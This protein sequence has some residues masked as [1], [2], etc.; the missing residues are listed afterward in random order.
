MDEL[1]FGKVSDEFIP[2]VEEFRAMNSTDSPQPESAPK[3]SQ[4][5]KIMKMLLLV[6][7]AAEVG[8]LMTSTPKVAAL[9]E[10]VVPNPEEVAAYCEDIY[11]LLEEG[12]KQDE[13]IRYIHENTGEVLKDWPKMSFWCSYSYD[14]NMVSV[15]NNYTK[16]KGY[17]PFDE[18][19][20][21]FQIQ[22]N[23][24][25][26]ETRCC[27]TW[28]H[29]L[30][31]VPVQKEVT[32]R[33]WW[34]LGQETND[35]VS[36]SFF[37]SGGVDECLNSD[38]FY[39]YHTYSEFG[40]DDYEF[41]ST[42]CY[43]GEVRDGHFSGDIVFY[44]SNGYNRSLEDVDC[45]SVIDLTK[46][47]RLDLEN[48]EIY[49]IPFPCDSKCENEKYNA[50]LEKMPETV[51]YYSQH[52]NGGYRI[53]LKTKHLDGGS[54]LHRAIYSRDLN[55][56]ATVQEDWSWDLDEICDVFNA[57]GIHCSE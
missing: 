52:I 4:T 28:S 15:L 44:H 5:R 6:V 24:S 32:F 21:G 18:N 12:N 7:G 17:L 8:M 57:Y 10:F 55:D 31:D 22:W 2:P 54:E 53:W 9:Q 42:E 33:S 45:K 46:D 51:Q 37:T 1:E 20:K 27:I 38:D 23:L 25:D 36:G 40:E 56:D 11:E 50:A 19:E 39:F 48:I 43:Q 14:E 35:Y 16:R 34:Q 26:K 29:L 41:K 47:G 3:K 49:H 13:I 30:N